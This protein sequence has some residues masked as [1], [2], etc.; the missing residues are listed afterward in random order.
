MLQGWGVENL[1][2]ICD[3]SCRC[4]RDRCQGVPLA[5]FSPWTC[6]SGRRLGFLIGV[7]WVDYYITAM[8]QEL[9][10]SAGNFHIRIST[11]SIAVN[12]YPCDIFFY[13]LQNF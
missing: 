1:N 3:L 6:F 4:A 8:N 11:W 9:L 5:N 7:Y 2:E 12:V 10:E 13:G